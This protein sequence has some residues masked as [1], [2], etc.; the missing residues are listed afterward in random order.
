MP[1]SSTSTNSILV[2]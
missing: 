1:P 2:V